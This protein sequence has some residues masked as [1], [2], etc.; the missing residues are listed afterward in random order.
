MQVKICR[1][2]QTPILC[3]M[4]VNSYEDILNRIAKG[5]E[6]FTYKPQPNGQLSPDLHNMRMRLQYPEL[7]F[8]EIPDI[9]AMQSD[10][11]DGLQAFISIYRPEGF[12]KLA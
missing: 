11:I 12:R 5:V 7:A 9:E 8:S 4:S 10:I 6:N 1:P 2:L 3:N